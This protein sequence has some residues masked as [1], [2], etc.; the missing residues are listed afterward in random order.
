MV[1]NQAVRS[2]LG[3]FLKSRRNALTPASVGLSDDGR[4]RRVPGLRREEV[5]Q[6]ASISVQYYTR[7]EQGRLS[8]SVPVLTVLAEV[9]RL[10]DD[11][12]DY[13]FE[14]AGK[15]NPLPRRADAQMVRPA[16]RRLL[17][18]LGF[19]AI[20]LGR[21]MD[22]L[23]WNPLAAELLTDFSQIP[24]QHRNY[25]RLVFSDSEMRSRY[26]NWESVA[27][28]CVA[29]LRMEAA[30]NPDDPRLSALVGELCIKDAHFR[31][32]WAAHDVL[33]QAGGVKNI[34]HPL[35]GEL[36]LDWETLAV[37]SDAGQQLVVWS[38]EPGTPSYDGLT[39]L[40]SW[41][42]QEHK[43]PTLSADGT[44]GA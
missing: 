12:R 1:T 3:Q 9:L 43:H 20:I 37:T 16:T 10:D 23:A 21:R 15:N 40:A 18:A 32:W 26:A 36:S 19:P 5:A 28:D 35:V 14:L 13:L 31:Q 24:S 30:H 44:R 8:A 4:H 27:A 38:A 33:S 2:E 29:F 34:R 42:G 17:G 6:L 7:V 41:A 22:I 11:Q 25:A 39:F